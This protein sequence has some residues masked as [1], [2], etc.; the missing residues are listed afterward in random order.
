MR[1]RT[2]RIKIPQRRER[3]KPKKAQDTTKKLIVG[4][5]VLGTETLL[6]QERKAGLL[7]KSIRDNF[8]KM[9]AV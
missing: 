4:K 2:V 9:K 3:R 1:P 8:S 6:L 7:E 5:E